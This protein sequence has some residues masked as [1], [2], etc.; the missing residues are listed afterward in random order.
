MIFFLTGVETYNKGAELML[1]AILQEIE[2]KYPGS[3]VYIKENRIRQGTSYIKTNLNLVSL[4]VPRIYKFINKFKIN[5]I[6][7]RLFGYCIYDT[8]IIKDVNYLL[9]GSGLHFSD[10][11]IGDNS[12]IYLYWNKL[13]KGY[14]KQN[15]KIVF[16]PQ[17]FGPIERQATY[18]AI[19]AI[20]KYAD[21]VYAREEKSYNYLVKS[22]AVNKSKLH[23]MTDFTSL[24]D[25][26]VPQKYEH[27]KNAVCVIPNMQMVRHGGLSLDEYLAYL[28]NII[29]LCQSQKHL[30]Y[31]LNHE[32]EKDEELAYMCKKRLSNVEV[33][34]GLNAIHTKGMISSAYLVIS[35]RFHGVASALNCCVPCLATSWSHKYQ[36]L[37]QDYKQSDSILKMSYKE[38][39]KKILKYLSVDYNSNV[40]TQ[41]SI[42]VPTI[43]SKVKMMW[44]EIWS[45]KK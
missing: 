29:L 19:K 9:D 34:S 10:Q 11:T 12:T 36:Y 39:E 8:P 6:L 23:I 28:T 13:L 41:L 17:G 40:R 43:Q 44:N 24:V 14:S 33:V 22:K 3:M 2:R 1:Y 25:G 31:L 32:G 21:L 45:V 4:R 16:L 35:S 15:T 30:V 20:D 18:K 5:S 38:D 37:F 7:K 26:E 42:V 27:L